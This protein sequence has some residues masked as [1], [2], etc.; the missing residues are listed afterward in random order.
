MKKK[1]ARAPS[2]GTPLLS[3]IGLLHFLEI[4]KEER[5][6]AIA[7]AIMILEEEIKLRVD[8]NGSK[9]LLQAKLQLIEKLPEKT[10]QTLR[11][12]LTELKVNLTSFLRAQKEVF[13]STNDAVREMIEEKSI[14]AKLVKAMLGGKW[15]EH[16]FNFDAVGSYA[17][18]EHDTLV[19]GDLEDPAP[20]PDFQLQF[21]MVNDPL[22]LF[23]EE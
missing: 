7:L 22:N 20:G 21:K 3:A 9:D 5:S 16:P 6:N 18:S 14:P 15:P 11:L 19:P 12:I 4:D 23:K 8:I 1:E 17:I 10:A 13:Y 2:L